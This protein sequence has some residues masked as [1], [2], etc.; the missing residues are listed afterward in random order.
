MREIEQRWQREWGQAGEFEA[1]PEPGK[2]KYFATFPYPYMNGRL[3]LGHAFTLSKAEFAVGFERMRGKTCLFPLGFHCTGMPI[4][5]CADKLRNEIERYGAPPVY[6]EVEAASSTLG[7][8]HSKVAAKTGNA[9]TQ[10]QIMGQL[11]LSDEEIPPFADTAIW[12]EYFPKQTQIDVTAFGLKIDWRRSFITTDANPYY[13]SFVRWQFNRLRAQDKIRFGKRNTIYSPVDGQACL[14]HDRS[15]GEGVG[16]QEYTMILMQVQPSSSH[17]RNEAFWNRFPQLKGSTVYLGA[18]TLRPE[19]MY[20]QT[21]CW[22]GP[23][24]TYGA[25]S[26]KIFGESCT[27]IVTERAARN[28]VHQEAAPGAWGV[29]DCICTIPATDLIGVAVNAPLAAQYSTVYVLP[30][31][32]VSASKGT[33]IVTSV[34]SDSPDDFAALSDLREKPALRKKYEIPDDAIF[35]PQPVISTEAYGEMIAP[36]LISKLG[37]KSQNDRDALLKA[38]EVAYAEAY[39]RGTMLTG[40]YKGESV[41]VAK[42]KVRRD[43]IAA[44][45][46]IVYWEPEGLVISRSGDE[47]VVALTDQWYIAYGE[48][49]WKAAA[50]ECLRGMNLYH[51]ETKE[52]FELAFDWIHQWACSRSFGLGS[53]LPWD[54]QYLIESLSDST[55]YMAYYAVAHILHP[56]S[57]RGDSPNPKIRHSEMT[58]AVWDFVFGHRDGIPSDCT[59]SPE[60]MNQMRQQFEYFYPM[61]L[62]VSGK[63]LVPNHLTFSIYNHVALFPRCY[64]PRSFRA[65]GMLLLDNEKMSKSTGNF[66]TLAQSVSEFSADVTRLALAD[67][68]DDSFDANFSTLT[69]NAAILTLHNLLDFFQEQISDPTSQRPADSPILYADKVFDAEI[70][71]AIH[72]CYA[73][74]EAAE[75][76]SVVIQAF[77][78]LPRARDRYRE[79]SR[80][81][82]GMHRQVLLKFIRTFTVLMAPII[83]HCCEEIWRTM[84]GEKSS[85]TK[86]AWPVADLPDAALLA[87]NEYLTAVA[88]D[89][90]AALHLERNPKRGPPPAAPLTKGIIFVA[91]SLP[92]WQQAALLLLRSCYCEKSK[93]FV[94][95]DSIVS[96]LRQDHSLVEHWKKMMPFVMETKKQVLDRGVSAFSRDLPFKEE[97]ILTENSAY[98]ARSLELQSVIV[99]PI[100][101]ADPKLAS[102]AKPGE[103]V[104][105]FISQ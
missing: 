76:R 73:S 52:Q 61:D 29:C 22:V 50:L 34:P 92:A 27:L 9:K 99:Q 43:L 12:L 15:S 63:D 60:L 71:R 31:F 25:F 36:A 78:E 4:K 39:Y 104:F 24:I 16:A 11:G 7:A 18:A 20:A 72:R 70:N 54:P 51:A 1:N 37:I 86:A 5:A 35:A 68:G 2:A 83:P 57:I 82:G 45:L 6:P 80:E 101:K 66:L 47:C 38:K 97:S 46:A 33:G 56:D 89:M 74:Y 64:W 19:T 23:E 88:R 98:L 81:T 42:P 103:P 79:V 87:S 8:K 49:K 85:V 96:T 90:R 95:D 84:L 48:E 100:E 14:D 3:H 93:S 21:N 105:K 77:H 40:P 32:C 94:S 91:G 26:V 44:K 10:W 102:R 17:P 13:D 69:C 62:R 58:D 59:I 30:M 67:A 41:Q 28:L 75:Y 65:N 53:R 55:I